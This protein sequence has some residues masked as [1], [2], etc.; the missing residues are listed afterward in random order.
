MQGSRFK[1][2]QKGF[3]AGIVQ[4]EVESVPA[5][6]GEEGYLLLGA[7]VAIALVMIAMSVAAVK[8]SFELRREREEES[9]RRANQYVRAV[10]EFYLKFR[11][12]PGSVEQL[13]NTNNIRFLRQ[14]Y[15]DP[16]TGKADYRLIIVGQNKTTPKGFFGEPL[17][18]L[19]GS[20]PGAAA[21][22]PSGAPG[23][24]ANGAA[25]GT[26]L[27]GG[28]FGAGNGNIGT[29][30][31]GGAAA[32]QNLPQ[33]VQTT[34]AGG[35]AAIQSAAGAPGSSTTS[36]ATAGSGSPG[37]GGPGSNLGPI[38]GVG[39]SATGN[40]IITVNEQT[41]YENWEFLYDPRQELLRQKGQMNQGIG[42]AGGGGNPA[43]LGGAPQSG[44]SGAPGGPGAPAQPGAPTNG[45]PVRP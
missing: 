31:F 18:G 34:G 13:E 35:G 15:V 2:E 16:L 44:A 1:A 22:G 21:G 12:Y 29:M 10:R 38:M 37:S 36:S 45:T 9:A 26:S 27:A 19:P 20:G 39:S 3:R 7:I 41:S 43:G 30:G 23:A 6:D 11:R 40:S 33:G 42:T 32:A 14:K 5:R 28:A 17:S 25:G 8:V 24:A 4:R